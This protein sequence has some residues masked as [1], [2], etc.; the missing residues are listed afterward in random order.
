MMPGEKTQDLTW[1][2]VMSARNLNQAK[3]HRISALRLV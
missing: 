2:L 3:A 1:V